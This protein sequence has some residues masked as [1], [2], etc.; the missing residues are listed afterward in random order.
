[1]ILV[2]NLVWCDTSGEIHEDTPDPYQFGPTWK[3]DEYIYDP[4]N[5]THEIRDA[6]SWPEPAWHYTCPGPH[7]IVWAG[8][9][10]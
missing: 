5:W 7:R 6:H 3:I 8:R 9:E 2:E 10:T 1:M 4:E